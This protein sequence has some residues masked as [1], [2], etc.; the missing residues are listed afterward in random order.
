MSFVIDI[1]LIGI[2]LYA[3]WRGMKERLISSLF[4]LLAIIVSFYIANIG[5][6]VFAPEF[7]GLFEP[8][9]TGIVDSS[10]NATLGETPEEPAAGEDEEESLFFVGTVVEGVDTQDVRSVSFAVLRRLGFSEETADTVA[11]RVAER[12]DRVGQEMSE[13]LTDEIC[14]TITFVMVFSV[15]FILAAIIFAA[16]GNIINLK[17]EIPKFS[18]GDQIAGTLL[19]IAR[20]VAVVL[21]ITFLFR[22]AGWF[23][24]E[25]I[26]EKTT[27]AEWLTHSNAL[28]NKLGY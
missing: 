16:I 18:V 9:A 25:P 28:A 24:P 23:L 7:N 4:G 1:I 3:G 17:F 26:L 19:G 10:V 2:V 20:G 5:A 15:F 12:C 21:F 8:F 13:V 6:T 27:I 11:Q 22:F 14:T